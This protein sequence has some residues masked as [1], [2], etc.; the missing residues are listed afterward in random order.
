MNWTRRDFLRAGALTAM[1]VS[2]GTVSVQKA[3]AQTSEEAGLSCVTFKLDVTPEIGA[4]MAYAVHE[5]RKN[6]IYIRGAV[7]DDG[8]K[9]IVWAA[10]DYLFISGETYLSW[11]EKIAEAAGADPLNVFLHTI[12]THES[13]WIEPEINPGPG[14]AWKKTV[15]PEYCSRTIADLTA[16]IA[17]K[18]AGPWRKI[19]K[20]YTAEQRVW[21][22]ASCRR[23]LDKEGKLVDV[24]WSECSNP[25]MH[26]LPVGVIDPMLRSVVFEDNSGT[27]FLAFHF[28]ATHPQTESLRGCVSP[29]VPGFA[30]RMTEAAFPEME[31]VYFNGCG[32]NVTMGKYN[33]IENDEGIAALGSRL[34]KYI[35]ANLGMLHERETGN[36]EIVQAV[37]DVP[38]DEEILKIFPG[39]RGE[40]IYLLR[41]IDLWKK[42]HITRISFG[43]DIHLLSFELSEVS[44]EYQLYAQSL[45]PTL[46]LGTAAYGNGITEY[47]PTADAYGDGSYETEPRACSVKPEIEQSIKGAIDE[48]L[49]GLTER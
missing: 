19:A 16:L 35:I 26:Q 40:R 13:M 7:F 4:V 46:F 21:G 18:C 36:I 27:K 22:L 17:E 23:V 30:L 6:P 10:C 29:D 49:A 15:D 32:G 3:A 43:P 34:G 20:L 39:E 44:V 9:R 45:I 28:Y 37:F 24:R 48:V 25:K 2:G 38:F 1:A 33:V 31:Q 14:D 5:E 42:S 8:E 12:H 41:T 47:V 11:R